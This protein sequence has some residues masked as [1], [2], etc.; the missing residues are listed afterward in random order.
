MHFIFFENVL[1]FCESPHGSLEKTRSTWHGEKQ[2]QMISLVQA[3]K[4]Y[5]SAALRSLRGQSPDAAE[6]Y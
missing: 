3:L 5:G 4:F 2:T 1:P 6:L